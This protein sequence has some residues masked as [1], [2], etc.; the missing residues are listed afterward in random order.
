MPIMPISGG[1]SALD[2]LRQALSGRRTT[3]I[4]LPEEPALPARPV[5]YDRPQLPQLPDNLDTSRVAPVLGQDETVVG[6]AYTGLPMRGKMSYSGPQLNTQ[7]A[8]AGLAAA[9]GNQFSPFSE[10][11]VMRLAS[12]DPESVAPGSNAYWANMLQE[13]QGRRAQMLKSEDENIAGI[14]KSIAS[15]HP[16]VQ[17]AAENVAERS[18]RGQMVTA[19][20]RLQG[21]LADAD[22]RRYAAK[23]G[24]AGDVKASQFGNLNTWINAMR[25]I[26]SKSVQ[27][28][29]DRN[30]LRILRGLISS[31]QTDQTGVGLEDFEE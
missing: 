3:D 25:A 18:S 6:G 22:A 29:E 7:G 21:S 11:E 13:M 30:M 26:Q 17:T 14:N 24:L 9:Q 2:S 10:G 31:L 15:L 23:L 5:N 4:E 8:L 1:M 16:A 28:G 27:T 12:R 20:A 19:Q